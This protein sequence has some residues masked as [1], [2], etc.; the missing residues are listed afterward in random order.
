MRNF[1]AFMILHIF[2]RMTLTHGYS[3]SMVGGRLLRSTFF[4][5]NSRIPE[6]Y[7]GSQGFAR[8]CRGFDSPSCL[9]SLMDILIS[10]LSSCSD[11][12]DRL[13]KT[14]LV[15]V[16]QVR[17]WF[18]RAGSS[19]IDLVVVLYGGGAE[20]F[21]V[22]FQRLFSISP[23]FIPLH[24]QP[25]PYDATPTS[26]SVSRSKGPLFS[27]S[28]LLVEEIFLETFHQYPRSENKDD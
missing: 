1:L 25:T 4:V 6:L 19:D 2:P 13:E 8:R 9:P 15:A 27:F 7:V 18:Q 5:R 16:G 23:T 3:V 20:T 21:S 28:L 17:E 12:G 26:E 14:N 22:L 24:H 11:H 10:V